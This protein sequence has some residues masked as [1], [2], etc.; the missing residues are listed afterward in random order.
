MKDISCAKKQKEKPHQLKT[1]YAKKT[2]KKK[3]KKEVD[4]IDL[5]EKLK[6]DDVPSP[7]IRL[8]SDNMPS[9]SVTYLPDFC[10]NN[11]L[12][13]FLNIPVISHSYQPY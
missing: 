13:D 9:P 10:E 1:D 11:S 3:S 5:N 8:N 7:E 6:R 12:S 2:L 4:K